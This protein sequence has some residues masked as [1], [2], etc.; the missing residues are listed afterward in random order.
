[1]DNSKAAALQ[2]QDLFKID[3][4]FELDDEQFRRP[5]NPDEPHPFEK[6]FFHP[7]LRTTVENF[8]WDEEFTTAPIVKGD[9][10]K[11][12]SGYGKIRLE[13]VFDAETGQTW[14]DGYDHEGKCVYTRW[15]VE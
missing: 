7:E 13:K 15:I 4:D 12:S 11:A 3:D 5:V 14:V 10:S 6:M 8:S 9:L 2:F 1:M